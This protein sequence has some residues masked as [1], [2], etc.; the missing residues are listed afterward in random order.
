MTAAPYQKFRTIRN[1]SETCNAKA[2]GL[3]IKC[4]LKVRHVCFF[5]SSRVHYT[6]PIFSNDLESEEN[7]YCQSFS[8]ISILNVTTYTTVAD[9]TLVASR[10]E[11]CFVRKRRAAWDTAAIGMHGT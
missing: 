4:C 9:V 7:N 8:F 10:G 6:V 5:L 3:V 2:L 11:H 1:Q